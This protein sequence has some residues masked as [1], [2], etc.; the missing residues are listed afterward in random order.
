MLA[1]WQCS[2][3]DDTPAYNRQPSH[4]SSTPSLT[5]SHWIDLFGAGWPCWVRPPIPP[6]HT[7]SE[8]THHA[9]MPQ[10]GEHCS[11]TFLR[12][13]RKVPQVRLHA[14]P[15]SSPSSACLN[16]YAAHACMACYAGV[17]HGACC[18]GRNAP[19]KLLCLK[20]YSPQPA[21]SALLMGLLWRSC[22]AG[23]ASLKKLPCW[24]GFSEKVALLAGTAAG[25]TT[26]V[27]CCVFAAPTWP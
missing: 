13:F 10:C 23:G 24:W 21:Q 3:T 9:C 5:E 17:L 2:V 4:L 26:S 18:S 7:A 14:P 11:Q 1:R 6:L 19:T 15:T 20:G 8:G 16:A 12:L 25:G 22:P 27:L